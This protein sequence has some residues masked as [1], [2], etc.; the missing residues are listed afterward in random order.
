ML[1]KHVK[2]RKGQNIPRWKRPGNS[3]RDSVPYARKREEQSTQARESGAARA[4]KKCWELL[5]LSDKHGCR[6]RCKMECNY[7]SNPLFSQSKVLLSRKVIIILPSKVMLSSE[8]MLSD[9]AI[10][11]VPLVVRSEVSGVVAPRPRHEHRW[12]CFG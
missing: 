5:A 8:V 7:I 1:L 3:W 12:A 10:F 2:R 4:Y 11:K 6:N 9:W